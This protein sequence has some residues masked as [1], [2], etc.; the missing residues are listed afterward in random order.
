MNKKTSNM[1]SGNHFSSKHTNPN[2]PK[3]NR[4]TVRIVV[5][6]KKTHM[7]DTQKPILLHNNVYFQQNTWLF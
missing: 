6:S 2:T 1:F 3:H 4:I 7:H 5:T